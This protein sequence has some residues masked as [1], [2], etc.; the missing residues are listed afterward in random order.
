MWE[1]KVLEKQKGTVPRLLCTQ[2][3]GGNVTSIYTQRLT[4]VEGDKVARMRSCLWTVN[5]PLLQGHNVQAGD[6]GWADDDGA[7]MEVDR[8]CVLHRPGDQ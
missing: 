3:P 7:G 5:G 1:W 4:P 6:G 8:K 2:C